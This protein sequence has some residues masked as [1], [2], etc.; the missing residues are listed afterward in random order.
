MT[1]LLNRKS[2]PWARWK[3]TTTRVFHK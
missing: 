1:Y 3:Q 2:S